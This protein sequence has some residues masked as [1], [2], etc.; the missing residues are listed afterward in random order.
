MTPTS[1]KPTATTTPTTLRGSWSGAAG[2]VVAS[3]TGTTVRLVS[4]IPTDGYKVQSDG[5]G[6][7]LLEVEFEQAGTHEDDEGG[8][9]HLKVSCNAGAP[10]FRRD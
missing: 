7:T 2:K 6:G 10:A 5:S 3:C 4:A 8:E 1:A 9:T